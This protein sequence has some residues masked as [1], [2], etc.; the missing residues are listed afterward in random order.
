[1]KIVRVCYEYP[2]P[3][4]GLTPGP[5]ELSVAQAAAGHEVLFLAGGRKNSPVVEA[6][7][8]RVERLGRSWPTYLFG[9]FF[10]FD[11]KLIFRLRKI[12][13]RERVDVI[14]IHGNT[15]LWFNI[16][17]RLGFFQAVPYVFHA[18]SS[19][20][21]NFRTYWR[22]ADPLTKVKA[23]FIWT[24][25]LV[26]DHLTIRTADA[27]ITV[28]EK[29]QDFFIRFGHCPDRKIHAVENG[30][31]TRRFRPVPKT[32]RPGVRIIVAAY[33]RP[34][35]NLEKILSVIAV[36]AKRGAEP[37]LTVV[38][39]GDIDYIA[40]LKGLAQDLG[41]ESAVTWKGYIP[42]P[43]LPR[44]YA[45]HDVLLLLSHTEGLPKV[46]LEALS[47]GIAVVSTRSFAVSGFLN[48]LVAWVDDDEE[49]IAGT[50]LAALQKPLDIERFRREY[51]WDRKAEE[52]ELI[53]DEIVA[54]KKSPGL[55]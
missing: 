28:S 42:Y 43:E 48:E 44:L 46:V 51:S 15:A 20:Q 55:R 4:D 13:A 37:S 54:A 5:F 33:L 26:Q 36:L 2:P 27:L 29:E 22:K 14:H 23:L 53:Y 52:I 6:D 17:R 1:M 10:S 45:E 11:L 50:I 19:G 41:I 30:V 8:L 3:W 24:L 47:C 12:L 35:K 7:A 49:T 32:G 38:G 25:L 39:R 40:K 18:H 31:N 34:A 9:P 16:L 21:R